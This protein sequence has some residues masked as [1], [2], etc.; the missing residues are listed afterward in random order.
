M[1]PFVPRA[2]IDYSL[3]EQGT[4]KKRNGNNTSMKLEPDPTTTGLAKNKTYVKQP[5]HSIFNLR[6]QM[7]LSSSYVC[8][9]YEHDRCSLAR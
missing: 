4:S 2:G 9:T 8:S 7:I 6:L 3:L 5:P 1:D